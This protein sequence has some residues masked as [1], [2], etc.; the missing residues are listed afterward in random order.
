MGDNPNSDPH[1]PVTTTQRRRRDVFYQSEQGPPSKRFKISGGAIPSGIDG[2][3]EILSGSGKK[4]EETPSG[5]GK[6]AEEP[7]KLAKEG[8]RT[9]SAIYAAHKISSSFNNTHTINL[10]LD[11]MWPSFRQGLH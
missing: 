11:G 9:Q 2:E 7:I 5:S 8:P 3:E 10:I 4:T 6:K 1:V